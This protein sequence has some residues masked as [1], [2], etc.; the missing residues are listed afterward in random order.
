MPCSGAY[1][2]S[3]ASN[4]NQTGRPP[5]VAVASG[6]AV[7]MLRRETIEDLLLRDAG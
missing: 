1:H 6:A 7:P 2:S 5:V 4:Y 3:L